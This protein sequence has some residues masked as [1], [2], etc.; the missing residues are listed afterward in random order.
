MGRT[1][2]SVILGIDPGKSGAWAAVSEYATAHP[3][4]LAGKEVDFRGLTGL[5][6]ELFGGGYDLFAVIEKPVAMPKMGKPSLL[7][8]GRT[9]GILEGILIGLAIPFERVAPQ[10]WKKVMLQGL[11][12][13]E[14]GSSIIAAQRLFP[15][16]SLLRTGKCRKQDDNMA[17]ALLIAEYGRRRLHAGNE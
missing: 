14:K 17:E 6:N 11:N 16:V 13:K 7:N 15:K 8:Y 3:F 12:K 4:P 5:W 10:T 1:R 9:C 2:K